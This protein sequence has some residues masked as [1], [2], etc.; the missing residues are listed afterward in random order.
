MKFEVHWDSNE[1]CAKL[2]ANKIQ[3]ACSS[4]Q[5]CLFT[6]CVFRNSQMQHEVLN[7]KMSISKW[8]YVMMKGSAFAQYE[9]K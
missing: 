8:R 6:Q 1:A 4:L 3:M 7:N 9:N 2:Q 5:G